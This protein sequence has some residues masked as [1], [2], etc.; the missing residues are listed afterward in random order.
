MAAEFHKAFRD[1]NVEEMRRLVAAGVSPDVEYKS[2]MTPLMVASMYVLTDLVKILIELGANVNYQSDENGFTALCIA[3][4][5]R[6]TAD[7]VRMLLEAGADPNM[8][9]GNGRL[10]INNAVE[11]NNIDNIKLLI[12]YNVDVNNGY[13]LV[14][15]ASH[16][17]TEIVKLLLAQPTIKNAE[18]GN[19][20]YITDLAR[21]GRFNPEITELLLNAKFSKQRSV[22]NKLIGATPVP[23]KEGA[24]PKYGPFNSTEPGLLSTIIGPFLG[25]KNGGR[26]RRQCKT[27]K[28]ASRKRA[29][30]SHKRRA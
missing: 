12:K 19:G 7:I 9:D 20:R 1:N 17:R 14:L 30:K 27:K 16:G 26:R 11:Q 21:Q 4:G 10:P 29:A 15:A 2:G 28:R 24:D 25:P 3:V 5:R 23:L 13:P 18:L 8:K 6:G 22:F